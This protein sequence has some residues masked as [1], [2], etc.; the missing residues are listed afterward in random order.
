MEKREEK[1]TINFIV[2]DVKLGL[3]VVLNKEKAKIILV[4]RGHWH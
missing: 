3:L 4:E 1:T 2:G